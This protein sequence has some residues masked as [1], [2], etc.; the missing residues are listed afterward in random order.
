MNGPLLIVDANNYIHRSFHAMKTSGLSDEVGNLTEITFGLLRDICWLKDRFHPKTFGFAWDVGHS[1]RRKLNPTYKEKRHALTPEEE[2]EIELKQ[3]VRKQA[4]QL[5]LQILPTIGFRNSFACAGYEADDFIAQACKAIP[6]TEEVVICS[7]DHD[8]YQLLA[9]NVSIWS[10]R[11]PKQVTLQSFYRQYGIPP[12]RWAE[13]KALAGC[14][15]DNVVGVKG[16]GEKT[17]I[18]YITGNLPTKYKACQAI[19]DSKGQAVAAANLP[20]V[21]LPYEGCPEVQ[22]QQDE[23]TRG[24]WDKAMTRWGMQSLKGKWGSLFDRK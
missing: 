18:K 16:V 13:V 1:F 7:S 11:P 2:A 14:T 9:G 5:R 17:A 4:E 12:F 8:L 3:Q 15:S 23:V 21:R 22:W 6:K 10:P 19:M 20:L 24:N